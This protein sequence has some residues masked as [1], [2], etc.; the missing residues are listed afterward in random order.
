MSSR[1]NTA[2]SRVLSGSIGALLASASPA[3][4]LAAPGGDCSK[5]SVGR[6]AVNDLGAD[7]YQGFPVG[8]YPQGENHRP[9]AHEAAGIALAQQVVPLDANG[10]ANPTGA[11]GLIS[12]GMP[13]ATLEWTAFISEAARDPDLARSLALVDGAESGRDAVD[14]SN[15]ASTY[16]SAT[17]P[18]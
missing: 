5:T 18:A 15:P 4:A 1:A 11:I 17:I 6:V 12:I 7:L 9:A 14:I 10:I 13:N 8:L 2:C 3:I 16:W